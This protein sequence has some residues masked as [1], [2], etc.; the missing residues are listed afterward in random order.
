MAGI[1]LAMLGILAV[2]FGAP[3]LVRLLGE[4]GYMEYSGFT[5]AGL[6]RLFVVVT[7][8]RASGRDTSFLAVKPVPRRGIWL[9]FMV[10]LITA[11]ALL[12]LARV[13]LSMLGFRLA[14][15]LSGVN[16][17]VYGV[18]KADQW[19]RFHWE[20]VP[21]MLRDTFL[22]LAS[23]GVF[24]YCYGCLWRRWRGWT[25]ALSILLPVGALVMYLMPYIYS[26]LAD[27]DN[28]V[29][30]EGTNPIIVMQVLPGWLQ[31]ARNV[32]KWFATY[33]DVVYWAAAGAALAAGFLVM[34]TMRLQVK[35]A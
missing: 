22:G 30:S 19:G 2:M 9:G 24:A 18:A 3:A 29:S 12:T 23:A 34:R 28:L 27:F 8:L 32:M 13:G 14:E 1:S 15:G 4:P 11:C 20:D 5:D 16:P 7:M 21:V 17:D 31:T 26:I 25:V 6:L 33:W 10:F 35:Q